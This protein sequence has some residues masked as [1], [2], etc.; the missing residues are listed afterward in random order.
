MILRNILDLEVFS[1]FKYDCFNLVLVHADS[2]S[3][4]MLGMKTLIED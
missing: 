3:I 4:V 2:T 1:T